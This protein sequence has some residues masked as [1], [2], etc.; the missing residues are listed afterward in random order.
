MVISDAAV[1]S[2]VRQGEVDAFALLVERYQARCARLALRLLRDPDE[3]ADAVQDAFIR[4]YASMDSYQERERFGSWLLCIVANRC[5]S[6]SA[7]AR[8]R[9]QLASEW[10]RLHADATATD[11]VIDAE[12]DHVLA[13]RLSAALGELPP[14]TRAAVVR[15]YADELTYEEIAADTGVTVSALKMRVSR[16]SAQLRRTLA[17]TGIAVAAIALV[18]TSH[19]PRTKQQRPVTVIACDTL[20]ALMNDTL[21][22]AVNR[23]SLF[24][25]RRCL[26]DSAAAD[27]RH[28]RDY[29]PTRSP[30][31]E[32]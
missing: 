22:D 14:A 17:G 1:I 4:A 27:A 19:K 24:L 10:W 15:K 20:R 32:L 18:F 31:R 3:A 9:A 25:P 23:D 6:A 7:S 12:R 13:R 21:S 2:R 28:H 30:K 29:S 11:T 8:R 26:P 5:R 16:G